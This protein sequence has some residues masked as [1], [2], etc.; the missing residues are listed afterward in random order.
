[1]CR[2][3]VIIEAIIEKVLID[4]LEGQTGGLEGGR[5]TVFRVV[6]SRLKAL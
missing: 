3:N 2:Y 1:M 6:N 5:Q 4:P